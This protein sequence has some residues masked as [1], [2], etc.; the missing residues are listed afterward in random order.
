ML[1]DIKAAIFDMDG[2]LIDSMWVWNLIDVTY[3]KK[4]NLIMPPTLRSDIEHLSFLETAQ[5]FKD[6]FNLRDSLQDIMDEWNQLAYYEYAN[7]VQLK[8]FAKEFL[9]KLKSLD[10]KLGLATSNCTF[11]LETVLK[12]YGIYDIFN[13]ITTTD[14]VVRGKNFPDIYLLAAEKLNIHPKNCI[15]FEDILP[16]VIGAKSAG[17]R[18]IGVHDSYAEPQQKE[19]IEKADKYI[20]GYKELTEAV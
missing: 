8:P 3:L 10:I 6:K 17:M 14:E 18:V 15:V 7:N 16:A 1:K 5:Y 2:T 13:A 19:I 20:I 12:K 9:L 11:L 4:R